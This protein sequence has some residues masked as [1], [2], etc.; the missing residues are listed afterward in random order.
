MKDYHKAMHD[1]FNEDYK[2][3]VSR[4]EACQY[5][6]RHDRYCLKTTHSTCRGCKMFEPS[7][8][9]KLRIVIEKTE[10]LK[11]KIREYEQAVANLNEEIERME[12]IVSKKDD[13]IHDLA[14]KL[15]DMSQELFEYKENMHELQSESDN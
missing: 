3:E 6:G 7:T 5:K 11:K 9:T 15:E 2:S 13:R 1:L 14:E 4:Q 10:E 12:E 8:Q